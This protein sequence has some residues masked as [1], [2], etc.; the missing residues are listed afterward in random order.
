[1]LGGT[2]IWRFSDGLN[3]IIVSLKGLRSM[4]TLAKVYA[5]GMSW[6]RTC[7][8]CPLGMGS[9]DVFLKSWKGAPARKHHMLR[10]CLIAQAHLIPY[11][12]ADALSCAECQLSLLEECM[13]LSRARASDD[14]A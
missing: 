6:K 10:A 4:C 11:A 2:S 9:A 12:L 5:V 7:T 14:P 1:M 13:M 3:L 8:A